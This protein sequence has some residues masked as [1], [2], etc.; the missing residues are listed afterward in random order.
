MVRLSSVAMALVL[1]LSACASS[2]EQPNDQTEP[3][4]VLTLNLPTESA[5]D[6]PVITD[7]ATDRTFLNRGLEALIRG[8]HIEAVQ[9][10][11]RY[12]RLEKTPVAGWETAV[13]IAFMSSLPNSPFFEP[14][15]SRASYL[16]LSQQYRPEMGAHPS[17]LL[18]LNSL[19]TFVSLLDASDQLAQTNEVLKSDLEKREKALTRL[20]DLTLGSREDAL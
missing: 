4:P 9:Y 7:E 11:Q 6:C 5:C 10:F 12:R 16:R 3:A 20:R 14:Q 2:P 13:S 18:M 19:E 1:L 15:A 17:V 8:D